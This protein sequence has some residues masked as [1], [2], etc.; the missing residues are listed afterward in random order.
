MAYPSAA[1]DDMI[2]DA[3]GRVARRSSPAYRA[4]TLG[5]YGG[6]TGGD[7]GYTRRGGS[8][9]SDRPAPR[10][11]TS[12]SEDDARAPKESPPVALTTW[13][14]QVCDASN[15][16]MYALC[17]ACR[18]PN[19]KPPASRAGANLRWV[20]PTAKSAAAAAAVLTAAAGGAPRGDTH[21]PAAAHVRFLQEGDAATADGATGVDHRGAGTSGRF[22]GLG[23]VGLGGGGSQDRKAHAPRTLPP[24]ASLLLDSES[25]P[26]D[27]TGGRLCSM[28]EDA[29][30]SRSNDGSDDDDDDD[31]CLPPPGGGGGR[32]RGSADGI[33]R[34]HALRDDY[35]CSPEFCYS[36]ISA[37]KAVASPR[38]AAAVAAVAMA[39]AAATAAAT[40]RER[41]PEFAKQM[42]LHEEPTPEL[43]WRE[44]G[45]HV[46][47]ARPAG[48]ERLSEDGAHRGSDDG[49]FGPRGGGGGG[50]LSRAVNRQGTASWLHDRGVV[51]PQSVVAANFHFRSDSLGERRLCYDPDHAAHGALAGG[52]HSTQ[53]VLEREMISI[54]AGGRRNKYVDPLDLVE[55]PKTCMRVLDQTV[56]W[57]ESI[58]ERGT[59][60]YESDDDGADRE[61]RR[62]I[63]SAPF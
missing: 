14:C 8:P 5:M 34:R 40:K 35:D 36:S 10:Q 61:W 16:M 21:N 30:H 41:R 58:H 1:I 45:V 15:L 13:R 46:G 59:S 7:Y 43:H 12:P 27:V 4:A 56:A 26:D 47:S 32:G 50:L 17:N 57:R 53:A 28:L 3:S 29:T 6:A 37:R 54:V 24:P 38:G 60:A 25:S 23:A 33:T 22:S 11:M 62:R 52:A 44:G 2:V 18:A 42:A 19:P 63:P 51:A 55:T 39:A 48:A 9:R 20:F 31:A 49:S